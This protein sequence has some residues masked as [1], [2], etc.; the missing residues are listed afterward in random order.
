MHVL[1]QEGR[2]TE[3]RIEKGKDGNQFL[4]ALG[5]GVAVETTAF[6]TTFH[7]E[8]TFRDCNPEDSH[9]EWGW[10]EGKGLA[11]AGLLTLPSVLHL[12]LQGTPWAH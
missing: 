10:E 2:D 12:T 4:P 6:P 3:R 1:A 11:V 9:R 5:P 7:C 8:S